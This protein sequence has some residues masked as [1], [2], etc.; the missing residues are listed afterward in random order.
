M[1]LFSSH[2]VNQHQP[3]SS[4]AS[5]RFLT[6]LVIQLIAVGLGLGMSRY[7]YTADK[8]GFDSHERMTHTSQQID[9]IAGRLN[10]F[11]RA[12]MASRETR[13]PF[14]PVFAD[15]NDASAR[16]LPDSAPELPA[17]TAAVRDAAAKLINLSHASRRAGGGPAQ[18]RDEAALSAAAADL[19]RALD[20]LR[21]GLARLDE[22]SYSRREALQQIRLWAVMVQALAWL[23]TLIAFACAAQLYRHMRREELARFVVESELVAERAAL[24]ERVQKRTA[25]LEA[26]VK[27]RE[28]AEYLNRSRNYMLEMVARNEPVAEIFKVLANTVAEIRRNA[29]CTIHSLD[30][31]EL[32][33]VASSGSNDRLTHNLELIS[34]D[35]SGAPESV[36]S[37]SIHPNIIEDLAAERRPWSE[38]LCANGLVSVW[39][40]PFFAPGESVLGTLTVYVPV[41]DYVVTARAA[42]YRETT[43]STFSITVGARQRVDLKLLSESVSQQVTVSAEAELL[44]TD[45]SD[46]SMVIT[47]REV[48]N[49]PLNGRDPADLA[50]LVAGVNKSALEIEGATSR[51]AAYNV[52][53]LRN[54]VNSFMIDGLDNN[55]WSLNDLGFSNQAIQLSPDAL[56]EFRFTTGNQS[57]QFGQAAGGLSNEV[58]R[59]GTNAIHG[60]A[61]NFLRNTVFNANGPIPATNGQKS[62][63][64]QNQFGA[65]IGG[66]VRRDKLFLFGDYEGFRRILRAPQQATLPSALQASGTFVDSQGNAIPITNPYTNAVYK[67]GI[68]PMAALKATKLPGNTGPQISALDM[69]VL[70]DLPTAALTSQTSGTG[71]NYTSFPLGTEDSDKGDARLDYYITPRMTTFVRYSQRR[72]N[73]L[74]PAPIPGPIYST[75]KGNINQNNKQLAAGYT[76]QLSPASALDLRVGFTWCAGA[77]NP[78]SIGQP[79]LLADADEPN[80]PSQSFASGLNTVAV[81]GFTQFGRTNSL[82]TIVNPFVIDPKVNYSIL[83]G[84]HSFKFGYE[85]LRVSSLVSNF[86]PVFGADTYGGKFSEG[87]AKAVG[88]DPSYA[89][90]WNLAD[91]IFGARS[92]YELSALHQVEYNQRMHFFYAQDDWRASSKLTVNLGLRY[93]LATPPYETNNELANFNPATSA[94]GGLVVASSGSIFSRALIHRND[95]NFAPRVGLAYSVDPKTVVRAAYGIS[96]QQFIRAAVVNELAQNAPYNIDNVISQ[97]TPYS[98]TSPEA[99]CSSLSAPPL[100]CFQPTQLGYMNNFLSTSNYSALSTTTTYDTASTPTTYIESYQVSLQTELPGKAVLDIAYVGNHGVHEEILEDYNEALPN[101]AGGSLSLQARRPIPTYA[102]IQESFNEGPSHYNALE[103]KLE[104]RYA[105]G[106]YVV[107]SLTWSHAEDVAAADQELNN[108]DSPLVDRYDPAGSF[109]RSAYDHPIN[110]SLAVVWDLPYGKGMTWGERAGVPLQFAFGDWQ[111]TALN[112]MVSGLPINISYAESAAQ[113]ISTLTSFLYRPNLVGIPVLANNKRVGISGLPGQYRYLDPTAVSVPTAANTPDGDCPRNVARAPGYADLDLGLHK[114][115]P[116]GFEN[117]GLEFRAEAFDVLNRSNAQ[118]PDS[119]ATDSGYGVISSYYPSRELQ[120]ALK[121]IF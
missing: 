19:E 55:S 2:E 56:S 87:T 22:A 107:N 26:E 116:L 77:Q 79:N 15:M 18:L 91:F 51:E 59:S 103:V 41:G 97:Y 95:L 23:L 6:L 99:V 58:S 37:L 81:T 70:G 53:G 66:P 11:S 101:V 5:G 16:L 4:L 13:Q 73:A 67:N 40:A 105:K 54:Q 88:T 111:F 75:A 1:S 96:Y 8:G 43:I 12:I 115:F 120:M 46:R 33:L 44:E 90:A 14:D 83:R 60:A 52:N 45:S 3:P 76:L 50:L 80:V 31:G 10:N 114:R 57:A 39:S 109:T 100:S 110:D 108:N 29:V 104:K 63:L 48:V 121:L 17:E 62:T 74:D 47:H 32:K 118:A 36:A 42:R 71:N 9:E 21:N 112:T 7:V 119:V 72:F 49:L 92:K 106:V 98:K 85:Y 78:T 117:A 34:R 102:G 68:I 35:F 94:N 84:H 69:T 30:S 20:V 93:E 25:A 89:E 86:K 38:L 113:Q 28:R 64:I 24:E 82:P 61:W 27:E 65:A